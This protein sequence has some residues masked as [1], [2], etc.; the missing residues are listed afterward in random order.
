MKTISEL[1]EESNGQTRFLFH[2][3]YHDGPLTGIMLFNGEKVYFSH[4]DDVYEKITFT[5]EEIQEI[6]EKYKEL[7]LGE[8]E[9]DDIDDY[10]FHRYFKIYRLPE[11]ILNDIEYEHSLFEKYV[12]THT[13]YYY[14]NTCEL[15]TT[16]TQDE[17]KK[18]YDR[19]D[20]KNTNIDVSKLECIGEFEL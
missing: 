7:G 16:R 12:G 3:G 9:D 13:N 18:F 17:W 4:E 19:T 6:K 2:I 11:E 15:K 14:G 10:N 20:K 8:P 1:K 5:E